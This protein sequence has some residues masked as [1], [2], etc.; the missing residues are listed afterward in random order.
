MGEIINLGERRQKKLLDDD[1]Q[2]PKIEAAQHMLF[3]GSFV[4]TESY[5]AIKTARTQLVLGHTYREALV[6]AQKLPMTEVVDQLKQVTPSYV[7]SHPTWCVALWDRLKNQVE[8]DLN[9]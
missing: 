2:L 6:R 3:I 5:A 7:K 4:D 8:S 1:T 9:L